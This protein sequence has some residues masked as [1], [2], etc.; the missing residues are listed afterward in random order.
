[1]LQPEKNSQRKRQRKGYLTR[2]YFEKHFT[3]SNLDGDKIKQG[4]KFPFVPVEALKLEKITFTGP[5]IFLAGRYNKYS[6]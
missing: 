3:P 6:R 4:I 1:L 2:N 5:T